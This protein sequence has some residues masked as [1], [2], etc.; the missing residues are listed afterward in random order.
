MSDEPT[1][2]TSLLGRSRSH[3][4]I[5]D[6]PDSPRTPRTL[7][8]SQLPT[9]SSFL[10]SHYCAVPAVLDISIANMGTSCLHSCYPFHQA[11]QPSRIMG[12]TPDKCHIPPPG[13]HGR[14][15]NIPI[16]R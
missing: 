5:S 13:P 11:P 6:A 10:G 2:R 7:R 9:G 1:E 3:V 15:Q 4:K 12:H 16:S 14:V 8:T